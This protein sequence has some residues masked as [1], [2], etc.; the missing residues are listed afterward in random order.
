MKENSNFLVATIALLIL[1]SNPILAGKEINIES[2]SE[3]GICQIKINNSELIKYNCP[4]SGSP[5]LL[6]Y[7]NLHSSNNN[8]LVFIDTPWGNAC[9]G[10]PIHI[11]SQGDNGIYKLQK[12][13]DF[14]G[15]HYPTITSGP[16]GLIIK[17]PSLNIEGTNKKIPPEK[18]IFKNDFL[19]K[20]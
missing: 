12:A 11:I 8:V 16:E 14:C 5:T 10:G 9:D 17:I 6:L 15:G 4:N 2:K 13:I 20:E 7:S 18:W 3:K 19:V 1:Y